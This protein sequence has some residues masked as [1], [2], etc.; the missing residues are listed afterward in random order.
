MKLT[1]ALTASL[2]FATSPSF[3]EAY[4]DDYTAY[5]DSQYIVLST[6]CG[7]GINKALV[8]DNGAGITWQ[9]PNTARWCNPIG[10]TLNPVNDPVFQSGG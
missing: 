5:Q 3:A 10:E 8:I 7:R 6:D 4:D 2:L 1:H 9:I